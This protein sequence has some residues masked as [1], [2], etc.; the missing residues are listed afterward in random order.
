VPFH[1][2]T[3][4]DTKV[5]KSND[6][7]GV[8]FHRTDIEPKIIKSFFSLYFENTRMILTGFLQILKAHDNNF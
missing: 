2:L 1:L 7:N 6:L 8:K 5:Q 4:V 3:I